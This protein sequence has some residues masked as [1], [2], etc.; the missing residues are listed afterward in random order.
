MTS[1]DHADASQ[2]DKLL[3]WG[4]FLAMITTS[5]AFITRA[6]LCNDPGLWPTTFA[7]DKVQAAELF[8]AGIWSFAL[9]IILFSL[10][11]D[12]IGYKAAMVF[13]FLCYAG[14]A[15]FALMA[16]DTV[17]AGT[18]EAQRA[19]Y[20]LLYTGSVI[21]GL[22]NGT[23]E[24]FTNPVVATMYSREKTKW[25]NIL[26]AGWPA[27]LVV[28]GLLSIGLADQVKADWRILVYLLIAPAVVFVAL[29]ARCRFPVNERVASGTS[30]REMLAQFG[31]FGAALAA[32]L[33]CRQMD[34]VFDAWTA[35]TTWFVLGAAVAA[36]AAYA[37]SVT[38]DSG[39]ILSV[40][41]GNGLLIL[42]CVVMIPLATTE[43]GTDGAI[44]G[45]MEAPLKAVGAHPLWV[46]IYTSAI[47]AILRFNAGPIVNRISPLGLLAV[48]AVLAIAGLL[49]LSVAS[50]LV[51]IF[52]AAT[53]YGFGKSFFWPT[54]LGVVS[55]QTPKG[56][57]LTLNA[58]AGIGMLAVGIVGGPAIGA[59]QEAA[60]KDAITSKLGDATYAKVSK[61]AS[62]FLGDYTAV[63]E[64][65]VAALPKAEAD[66]VHAAVEGSRQGSLR[67]IALFPAVMLVVYLGLIA[68][69]R[70][71]GGYK[72]VT[73]GSAH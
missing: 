48:S 24:A 60:A 41:F 25:L 29:L 7:L 30:Y 38:V 13:S 10:V 46:L 58:I 61:Q 42:L 63:D 1:A 21:L 35:T 12:R 32:F 23:V 17:A 66:K 49:W 9:S 28:G 14:Y 59:I 73:L 71:K 39:S 69:F 15:V 26:H 3:F 45:I 8:G 40:A 11:I 5:L 55:E 65:K 27:G 50:G 18:P 19:A 64:A 72:P 57:A 20:W 4:C 36:F 34:Q 53:L 37:R 54:T 43:I 16:Y 51:A 67:T 52:A 31:V 47:M 62:Y 6:F 2:Q 56:G 68:W 33:M 22:G 44:T 70:R